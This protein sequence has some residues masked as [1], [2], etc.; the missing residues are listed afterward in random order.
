M[1]KHIF[2][3]AAIAVALAGLTVSITSCGSGLLDDTDKDES[4]YPKR[5]AAT[6]G[7]ALTGEFGMS[8]T[9]KRI[10]IT[11]TNGNFSRELINRINDASDTKKIDVTDYF[12][13]TTG[14]EGRVITDYAFKAVTKVTSSTTTVNSGLSYTS[15]SFTAVLSFV[16]NDSEELRAVR[17]TSGSIS[18][19]AAPAAI[20]EA[21][22]LECISDI[23]YTFT[24]PQHQVL[25]PTG[26]VLKHAVDT[27]KSKNLQGLSG[28]T[29]L[30]LSYPL[31]SALPEGQS[32][33]TANGSTVYVAKAAEAGS[34][35]IYA[36][37]NNVNATAKTFSG[38]ITITLDDGIVNAKET[39]N[40]GNV[41]TVADASD[42]VLV[43]LYGLDFN[44]NT[45]A[46]E[47]SYGPFVKPTL[48]DDGLGGWALC[49]DATSASGWRGGYT[50][51]DDK[52]SVHWGI[53]YSKVST[54]VVDF[55]LTFSALTYNDTQYTH[56]YLYNNAT[57]GNTS[58]SDSQE[59]SSNPPNVANYVLKLD[60]DEDR[61]WVKADT[62]QHYKLVVTYSATE[63]ASIVETYIDGVLVK[64]TADVGGGDVQG[65]CL[66]PVRGTKQTIDN[67]RIYV[68][69]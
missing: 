61:A 31:P 3:V 21:E 8:G 50:L 60:G 25:T 7:S 64:T 26:S 58:K 32:I 5:V 10:T 52:T 66:N 38:N 2:R 39:R 15:A 46:D 24:E 23:G 69:E 40:G 54:Y 67:I 17:T 9:D 18:I 28:A 14:T 42:T 6:A 48:V 68:G 27:I 44:E 65:I 55:D 1:K 49:E 11:V 45:V 12:T 33:G 41:F 53:D 43:P 36:I 16:I 19:A 13:L 47:V 4:F 63:G 59:L 37:L 62:T 51:N 30:T 20:A 34:G 56:F 57:T 35:K 22:A 29:L